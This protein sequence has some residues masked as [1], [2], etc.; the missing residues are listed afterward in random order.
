MKTKRIVGCIAIVLVIIALCTTNVYAAESVALPQTEDTIWQRL[1]AD[2]TMIVNN[3]VEPEDE[4]PLYN[5]CDYPDVPYG[6][7]GSV[8]SHGCGITC[9]AMVSTYLTD[10]EYTPDEMAEMFGNY[11]TV[12]GSYWILFEDSAKVLS[13][14]F[15]ERTYDW[16]T[17]MNALKNNQVVIALQGRGLFTGGGHFIV[18]A[19]LTEDGKIIVFDP[20]GNNYT[21]NE[22]LI[23]GFENG[24]TEKQVYADGGPYWIYSKKPLAIRTMLDNLDAAASGVATTT[25]IS[26]NVPIFTPAT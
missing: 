26:G 9:L 8:A 16:E 6:N 1:Y 18:L 4:M 10:I 15:Q 22:T 11:N 17:V 14:D 24:F 13:L 23:A 21:K 25:S 20:N 5:Q 19:G 2:A 3:D 7:Y 12:K